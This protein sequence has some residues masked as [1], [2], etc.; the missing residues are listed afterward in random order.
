MGSKTISLKDDVYELLKS[1]KRE[2]ESFSDVI[3]RL[4]G[5]RTPDDVEELGGWDNDP[6]LVEKMERT[7]REL[8]ED[9]EARTATDS[10]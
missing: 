6:D 7:A 5:D 4:A 1:R 8:N 2:G 9:L 3:E 10:E